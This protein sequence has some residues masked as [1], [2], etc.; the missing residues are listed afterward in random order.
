MLRVLANGCESRRAFG[1]SALGK[2]EPD[3]YLVG[4]A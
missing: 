3:A 1:V 2:P 4:T